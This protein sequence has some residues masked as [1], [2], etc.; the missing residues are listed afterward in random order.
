MKNKAL[1]T[2]VVGFHPIRKISVAMRGIYYAIILDAAV[3]YKV[4]L[5]TILLAVFFYHRQWIDF[6]LVL[7]VTG[8]VIISEI[9]NTAIESLCDFIESHQNDKI[10]IIKDISAGAVG[11]SIFTWLVVIIIEIYRASTI[12]FLS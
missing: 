11:V 6:S 7:V 5:S 9:F 10:G 4:V 2:G 3:A 8:M 12:F 1:N